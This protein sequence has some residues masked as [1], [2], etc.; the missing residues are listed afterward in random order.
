MES[1]VWGFGSSWMV[2][3]NG[4]NLLLDNA[5]TYKITSMYVVSIG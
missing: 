1:R 4:A 2:S 3:F 5:F